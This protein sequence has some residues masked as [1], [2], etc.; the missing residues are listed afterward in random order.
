MAICRLQ[1]DQSAVGIVSTMILG[2]DIWRQYSHEF[3]PV[4]VLHS[5]SLNVNKIAYLSSVTMAC[6][7][8]KSL[9]R[10]NWICQKSKTVEIKLYCNAK[11]KHISN[12]ERSR[13]AISERLFR[14]IFFN[15]NLYSASTVD[16]AL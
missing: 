1:F 10:F 6:N 5:M 14:G 9:T 16:R 4:E 8:L 13:E 11:S 2:R 12:L 3:N 7:N 15:I